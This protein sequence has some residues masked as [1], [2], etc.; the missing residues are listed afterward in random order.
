MSQNAA[1]KIRDIVGKLIVKIQDLED[2]IRK[3]RTSHE[4]SYD[5]ANLQD[6]QEIQDMWEVCKNNLG[7]Y[8]KKLAVQED[9]RTSI[10]NLNRITSK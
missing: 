1:L 8:E 10:L 3:C 6:T 2:A 4:K 7:R 5:L 9:L